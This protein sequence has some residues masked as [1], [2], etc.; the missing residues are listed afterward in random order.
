VLR[1]SK[2]LLR[3]GGRLAFLTI[4]VVPGLSAADHRRAV[5]AGPPSVAGKDTSALLTQA[6]FSDVWEQDVSAAYFE[7]ASAWRS[8]R[9]RY[10]DELRPLDPAAYD[11][12]MAHGVEAIDAIQRGWL[13]RTLHVARRP[14]P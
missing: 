9:L 14:E 2:R 6:G 5:T 8:A 12:R 13:R 1:A 4:Q 3:P 10:R 11:E 7:T